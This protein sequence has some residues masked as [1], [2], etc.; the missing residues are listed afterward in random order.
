ME[1]F[2]IKIIECSSIKK[3]DYVF[4]KSQPCKVTKI[5]FFKPHKKHGNMRANITCVNVLTNEEY[6]FVETLYTK[7]KQFEL[8]KKRY[9]LLSL[10]EDKSTIT[11]ANTDIDINADINA[12]DKS[13]NE[14]TCN[15]SQDNPFYDDV[16]T[17]FLNNDND[18]KCHI[19][20]AL[21]PIESLN[22]EYDIIYVI[23]ACSLKN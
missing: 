9:T 1:Q 4:Y 19:T 18:K 13:L 2:N 20:F 14:I 6:K 11:C 23:D 5:T 10:N 22:N 8:I 21:I 17:Y 3:N 12:D 16:K 15:F 7:F